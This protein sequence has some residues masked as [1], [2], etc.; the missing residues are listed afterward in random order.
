MFSCTWLLLCR[1]VLFA[2]SV[3]EPSIVYGN[4][5]A[6]LG[7]GVYHSCGSP[8]SNRFAEKREQMVQ[9]GRLWMLRWMLYQ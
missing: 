8:H 1:Y 9:L 5:D 4:R 2:D 7:H 6:L 3:V